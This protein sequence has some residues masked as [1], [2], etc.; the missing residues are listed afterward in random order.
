MGLYN[1]NQAASK[2][3]IFGNG[4]KFITPLVANGKVYIGNSNGVAFF[5]LI[6]A[7]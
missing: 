7:P 2:R 6:P 1:S 4:N 5:G 3:D